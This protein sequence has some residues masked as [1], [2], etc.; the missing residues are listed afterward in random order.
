MITV[1]S[2]ITEAKNIHHDGPAFIWFAEFVRSA[3]VFWRLANWFDP[4]TYAGNVYQRGTFELSD[5]SEDP[6]TLTELQLTV[7]NVLGI[8]QGYLES[9]ELLNQSMTLFCMTD[10]QLGAAAGAMSAPYYV[11][12]AVANPKVVSFTLGSWPL[13]QVQI[14]RDRYVRTKCRWV[15]KSDQCGFVGAE[16]TCDKSLESAGGCSGRVNQPRFGG[17]PHILTGNETWEAGI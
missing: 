5:I 16:T 9:D 2:A 11:Q 14:P 1:A 15:F 12:S 7:P 6:G 17:F 8:A 13:M 4:V 3:G 10:T